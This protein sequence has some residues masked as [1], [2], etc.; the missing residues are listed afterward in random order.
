MTAK[1]VE[2][3]EEVAL[4]VMEAM[5]SYEVSPDMPDFEERVA[6]L[7]AFRVDFRMDDEDREGPYAI[8]EETKDLCIQTLGSLKIPVTHPNWVKLTEVLIR[9]RIE[10]GIA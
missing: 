1:K 2:V 3:S 9:A 4:L 5:M 8:S 10:F 6:K 7:N